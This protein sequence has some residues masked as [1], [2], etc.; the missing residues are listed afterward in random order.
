MKYELDVNPNKRRSVSPFKLSFGS[1]DTRWKVLACVET[2]E[3]IKDTGSTG[4]CL[5]K[6]AKPHIVSVIIFSCF[7]R[8]RN[9]TEEIKQLKS[10]N[11]KQVFFFCFGF[12][13]PLSS[14]ELY[15]W[16]STLVW[17]FYSAILKKQVKMHSSF[18]S[19]FVNSVWVSIL[20]QCTPY[21]NRLNKW[22]W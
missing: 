1:W 22:T 12:F 20:L 17:Q 2:E 5:N 16:H 3:P 4:S 7:Y 15:D 10:Y 18:I 19:V 8:Q 13:S 11:L 21:I 9:W 14:D 6:E